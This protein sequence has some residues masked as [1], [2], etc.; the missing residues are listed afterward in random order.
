M[1]R[2]RLD[3]NSVRR[4]LEEGKIA[5]LDELKAVLGAKGTMTVF[6]R[7][8]ELGYLSSYSHRGKYY[9]LEYIPLR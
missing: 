3:S 1:S 6:R 8:K 4:F 9:T 7:L 2:R 5:T